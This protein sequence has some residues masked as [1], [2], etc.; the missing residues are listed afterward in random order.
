MN[1]ANRFFLASDKKMDQQTWIGVVSLA[2]FISVFL[3]D[4]YRRIQRPFRDYLIL[5]VLLFGGLTYALTFLNGET[6]GEPILMG[7]FED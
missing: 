5:M 2:V 6:D 7:S 1:V 3:A 4:R